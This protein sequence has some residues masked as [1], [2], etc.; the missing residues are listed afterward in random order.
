[1]VGGPDLRERR[2]LS[3][4]REITRVALELVAEHGL[5]EVTVEDIAKAAGVSPRTFFNYFT[6]KKSAVIPG[7][8]APPTEA[9]ERFVADRD[10]PVWEG[11]VTLLAR[12]GVAL[13]GQRRLLSLTHQVLTAHPELM[14]AVH[15]RVVE[16]ESSIVD[17]VAR[18]LDTRPDDDRPLVIAAAAGAMLRVAVTRQITDDDDDLPTDITRAFET[19]RELLAT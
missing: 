12:S 15:E 4:R 3:T 1:V 16:W 7:P 17:A 6:S 11:L 2:R 5:A 13:P 14:P 19:L 18:R 9:I 10:V 8:E